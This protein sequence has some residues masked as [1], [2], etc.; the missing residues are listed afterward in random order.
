MAKNKTPKVSINQFEKIVAYNKG[1]N[2]KS[3]VSYSISETETVEVEVKKLLSWEDFSS[4][5]NNVVEGCFDGDEYYSNL[6]DFN[7]M[8]NTAMYYTN[9]TLP[10]NTNKLYEFLYNIDIVSYINRSQYEEIIKAINDGI[11]F[12]KQQILHK[13][14]LNG[15][16]EDIREI[17]SGMKDSF[18]P[19]EIKSVVTKIAKMK[20]IN[21]QAII[22]VVKEKIRSEEE[23]REFDNVVPVDF[24]QGD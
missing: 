2:D 13:S 6:K 22:D 19:N 16:I 8:V 3:I 17:V 23:T 9:L 15:L 12:K 10:S 20:E 7:I 24:E 14:S 18:N 21:T 4:F 5:V 1:N 11:E